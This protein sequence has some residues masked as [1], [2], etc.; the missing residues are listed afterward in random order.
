[1]CMATALHLA[2]PGN[3]ASSIQLVT[4]AET[5]VRMAKSPHDF[6]AFLLMSLLSDVETPST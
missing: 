5:I 2:S 4:I 1:M 6:N 3:H